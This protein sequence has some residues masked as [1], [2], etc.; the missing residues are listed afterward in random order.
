MSEPIRV[1]RVIARLNVGGPALHVSYLTRELDARGYRTTLVAGRPSEGEGDMDYVAEELGITPVYLDGLQ[2][3]L[4]PARDLSMLLRLVELIRERRPHIVHTH[5]AKAGAVGRLAAL[6]AARRDPPLLVHTFHGHVLRGYFSPARERLFGRIERFLAAR[7]DALVAVSPQ[8]RDDLVGLR[9]A[10]AGR[11]AVVR[12]GIDLDRRAGSSG[13]R[14]A[15]RAR[16]GLAPDAVVAGWFGRMT[17]IKR[18]DVLLRALARPAAAAVSLVVVGD[19][20]LRPELEALA[21]DLGITGRVRFTGFERDVAPLF[22]ACDI[23]TLSSANEGTPVTLIEG[24]AAGLPAVA[25][26]VGGVRDV[27]GDA[28]L[29]VPAGDDRALAAVLGELAGDAERRSLL[30]ARGAMASRARYGVT[31]LVDDIDRLY[32]SLLDGRDAL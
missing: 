13:G 10:P 17:E 8:V 4:S 14:D 25:T 28:G 23:V 5:T 22:A 26:D 19:G 18:V 15:T 3:D 20:P 24:L 2:R 16:L 11:F 6:L 27:V 1:L 29:L 9:V 12:L 30:G 31:R 7:T 21:A 32:R